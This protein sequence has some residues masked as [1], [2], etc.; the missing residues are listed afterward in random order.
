MDSGLIANI[1]LAAKICEYLICPSINVLLRLG[2]RIRP[3]KIEDIVVFDS[4]HRALTGEE[5]PDRL[6]EAS[7]D[8]PS[9]WH[10]QLIQTS[11]DL[12]YGRVELD[13]LKELSIRANSVTPSLSG[14]LRISRIS[15]KYSI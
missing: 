14:R 2:R 12:T 6:E 1:N 8:E 7:A 11:E 10:I 13:K 9:I 4:A 3:V 15:P 5:I